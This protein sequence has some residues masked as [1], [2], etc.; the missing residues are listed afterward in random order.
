MQR[1]RPART[2]R[3]P[4]RVLFALVLATG[5]TTGPASRVPA[6]PRASPARSAPAH[7]VKAALLVNFG[8]FI[9][10]PERPECE[11]F[12]IVVIGAPE[13]AES[14]RAASPDLVIRGRRVAVREARD[15]SEALPAQV[16]YF[17]ED[18]PP[19]DRHELAR[20]ARASVLTVGDR[21]PFLEEGGFIR[22]AIVDD[23]LRIHVREGAGADGGLRPSSALLDLAVIERVGTAQA[24]K[25]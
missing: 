1:A 15:A 4:A 18:A 20:L 3:A 19:P 23:R 5:L 12:T 17:G 14:L 10:W 8:R 16:V 11:T 6:S 13:V 22:L 9:D 7:E 24:R 2:P 21:A 25:R